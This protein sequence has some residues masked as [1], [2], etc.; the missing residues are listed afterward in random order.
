MDWLNQAVPPV[1]QWIAILATFI[2]TAMA[3]WAALSAK[4]AKKLAGEAKAAATRLHHTTQIFD[5]ANDLLELQSMI[6]REDFQAIAAKATVLQ[7]RIVRFKAEQYNWLP[8]E[9]AEEI[10][11]AREQLQTIAENSLKPRLKLENRRMRIQSAFGYA[12]EVLNR[13]HAEAISHSQ[14]DES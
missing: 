10:D 5:L 14:T 8:A 12:F 13:L 7:G 6:V 11:Q 4:G 2:G 9:F 1:W 3:V